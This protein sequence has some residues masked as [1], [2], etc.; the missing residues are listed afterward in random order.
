[1]VREA[2]TRAADLYQQSGNTTRSVAML[3]R[4]VHD[5]PTPVG[6]A[7][8]VRQR[9]AEIAAKS[10][11]PERQRYWQLEIVKADAAAGPARTD[12]TKYLAAK[13]QLALAAPTR[14]AFRSIRLVAPLKQSLIA[15]K[16]ALEAAVQAYKQVA[17]YQV[18]ETVTAATFETAELYHTLA[19]DL[20]VSE[21]P[22]K[23]S[24]EELEQYESLLEEQAF[25]F[26]EQAITIHE[27]NAKRVLDGLY[28]DSVRDSLRALAEL[29][30]ARYG[31]TESSET[32]VASLGAPAV[33]VPAAV[34]VAAAPAAALPAAAV[35]LP[36]PAALA[37][38]QRATDLANAGKDADA[39]A[40]LRQFELQYSGFAAPAIDLGL[41][42]R[43]RGRLEDAQNSLQRATELDSGSAVAWTEL[44]V[45]LRQEG[46]FMQARA[47][48]EHALAANADY[49][50]AHRN[51]GVLLDLYLGDPAA[52]LP[53]LE[54]YK[55]LTAED[56]PVSTWIAELRTRTGSQGACSPGRGAPL[57]G[58]P[59]PHQLRPS[60]LR[61]KQL[62]AEAARPSSPGRHRPR[63]RVLRP[64]T[65]TEALHE[66][67]GRDDCE[68]VP[69]DNRGPGRRAGAG[70]ACSGLKRSGAGAERAQ[71]AGN[72]CRQ[73]A[74]CGRGCRCRRLG[75]RRGGQ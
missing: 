24:A 51:L 52:A 35:P 8:E 11:Q 74:R 66:C 62:P 47:A 39:E 22:K 28:D 31:K 53:E 70:A 48:Y 18:A 2:I 20:L 46:K 58:R 43:R 72:Y 59:R 19:H 44:G 16:K 41:I 73:P 63:S 38:F 32:W 56:K 42:A 10:G 26:E 61:P 69:Y 71:R 1:M 25:P 4:S 45:T 14:D 23:L 65:I 33:P 36:S 9:L 40:S 15:K 55:S 6:D 57:P 50:P 68:P 3:E 60:Q 5:Y 30:P 34:A 49:A 29:K 7:V 54:R 67:S 64:R 21:R 12:R 75:R 17:E 37:D 13:A 27:L